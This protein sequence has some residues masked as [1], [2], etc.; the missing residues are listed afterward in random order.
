MGDVGADLLTRATR[1]R[2]YAALTALLRVAVSSN[3]LR[4]R[5]G[6]PEDPLPTEQKVCRQGAHHLHHHAHHVHNGAGASTTGL[7]ITTR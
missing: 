6:N 5:T 4:K 1:S 7:F 2:Y 3:G